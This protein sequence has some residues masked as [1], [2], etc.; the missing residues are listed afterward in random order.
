[1]IL[2]DNVVIHPHVTIESGVKIGNDVE[3]FP[4]AYIG[5]VPKG[6]GNTLRTPTFEKKIIIDD[7]CQIGPNAVI[8]YDV[9][10]GKSTLVGDGASIREQNVIGENCII[11][12]YVTTGH[13]VRVGNRS[14]IMDLTCITAN[15][16]I[17]D[18]V[19]I[20]AL[21][22]TANQNDMKIKKYDKDSFIGPTIRKGATIGMCASILPG[23]EIGENSIIGT[24]SV[25]TKNIPPNKKAIGSPARIVE[26][27]T[28]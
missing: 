18:D 25:V 26:D 14:R 19:F 28:K 16:I 22:S 6:A 12:R 5:K 7:G 23:I 11:S 21:V 24:N 1:V 8:F 15:V 13:N 9:Y 4:G 2:G 20:S 17:E 27:Q 3:I 10:I